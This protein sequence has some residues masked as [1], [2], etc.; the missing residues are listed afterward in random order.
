MI[1]V[2]KKK[3]GHRARFCP[4]NKPQNI[5]QPNRRQNK[6]IHTVEQTSKNRT[7]CWNCHKFGHIQ[8]D[9]RNPRKFEGKWQNRD[10]SFNHEDRH[11]EFEN[12]IVRISTADWNSI[13]RFKEKEEN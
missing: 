7:V 1:G 11:H 4:Q 13:P 10:R 8:S 5:K 2:I 12:K 3:V 6:P 9:C